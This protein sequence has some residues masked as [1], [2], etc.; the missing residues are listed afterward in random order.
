MQTGGTGTTGTT[1]MRATGAGAAMGGDTL[2][3]R[4][5]RAYDL[6]NTEWVGSQDPYCRVECNGHRVESVTD[7]S[8][9][10]DPT[11]NDVV[12]LP[13]VTE[14]TLLSKIDMADRDVVKVSVMNSKT[15]LPDRVIGTAT[16]PL[17]KMQ[18][19]AGTLMTLPLAD[20]KGHPSGFLD[21]NFNAPQEGGMGATDMIGTGTGTG[22]GT[23]MGMGMGMG[24]DKT[25]YA[26]TEAAGTAF[27]AVEP[28]NVVKERAPVET[29]F[30]VETRPV[31]ERRLGA[32]EE[33]LGVKECVV[34][35]GVPRT[36][37]TTGHHVS[38]AG[39]TY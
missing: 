36:T 30:V 12:S 17:S 32:T 34:Q 2:R 18:S 25:G 6:K 19:Q 9:G 33:V 27:T 10:K 23:G 3:I 15:L 14:P 1:G 5:I 35:G 16:C 11:W 21:V 24:T 26:S 37:G 8:G 7:K 39:G 28:H 20:K 31:G 4:C 38:G 29:K 13:R 22:T